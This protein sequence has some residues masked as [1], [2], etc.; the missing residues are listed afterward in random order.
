MTPLFRV[1]GILVLLYVAYALSRGEVFAKSGWRGRTVSRNESPGY[2]SA[3][4]AIYTLLGV[5]LI[6]VF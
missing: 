1:L 3:V 6:T 4:I 5:A 2:F